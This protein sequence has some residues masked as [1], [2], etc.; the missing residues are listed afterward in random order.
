MPKQ[1][2]GPITQRRTQTLLMGLVQFANDSLELEDEKIL[3]GLRG[4]IKTHW[5]TDQRLVVQTTARHLV[6]LTQYLETPLTLAQVKAG[7]K[8]L[9]TFMGMLEDH[10]TSQ[11]GRISGISP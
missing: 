9:Q 2:F 3:A 6:A 11:R 4:T 8:H 7:L 1:S 10:R 5:Q